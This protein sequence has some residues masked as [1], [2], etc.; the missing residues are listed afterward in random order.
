VGLP[1]LLVRTFPSRHR[2]RR[3]VASQF[4][5]P[6]PEWTACFGDAL[7]SYRLDVRLPPLMTA[8]VAATITCPVLVFGAESDV[9][10]PGRALLARVRALLP[11]AET[12]L[13]EGALHCPP[14][15]EAFRAR[16]TDRIGR[17]L[18][19]PLPAASAQ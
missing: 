16:M 6:T 12:E 15:T 4:T 5:T 2:L 3:A 19:R 8:D 13:L 11:H 7:R 1:F 10:F 18:D 14:Q 9:S 17:F